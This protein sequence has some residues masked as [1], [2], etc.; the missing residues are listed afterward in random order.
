MEKGFARTLPIPDAGVPYRNA[1]D[2]HAREKRIIL[3]FGRLRNPT[4]DGQSHLRPCGVTPAWP[5][6]VLGLRST[7]LERRWDDCYMWITRGSWAFPVRDQRLPTKAVRPPDGS[8]SPHVEP[9]RERSI[10]PYHSASNICHS[11]QLI[12]VALKLNGRRAQNATDR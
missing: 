1:C 7:K 8:A 2:R 4:P 3:W 6:V 12:L 10:V 11:L 9:D 5:L